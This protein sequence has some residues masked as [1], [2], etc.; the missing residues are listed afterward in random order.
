M[1][2]QFNNRNLAPKRFWKYELYVSTKL[3]YTRFLVTST[4]YLIGENIEFTDDKT[5][6]SSIG[7]P[8]KELGGIYSA[9]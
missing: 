9:M 7:Q 3:V 2:I 1:S 4:G 6:R 5:S 8:S